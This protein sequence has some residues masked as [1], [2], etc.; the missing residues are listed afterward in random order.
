MRSKVSKSIIRT[1]QKLLKSLQPSVPSPD[2]SQSQHKKKRAADQSLSLR[3]VQ[4]ISNRIRLKVTSKSLW[5]DPPPNRP[6]W[7]FLLRVSRYF[8]LKLSQLI[9]LAQVN[10]KRSTNT[11][12]QI[13]K[14]WCLIQ[15]FKILEKFQEKVRTINKL[16]KWQRVRLWGQLKIKKMTL[17]KNW[18][19]TSKRKKIPK[20]HRYSLIRAQEQVASKLRW[21][22][23]QDQ[24][25]SLCK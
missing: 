12:L 14:S 2:Q 1:T 3:K 25:S 19:S 6:S 13:S 5:K 21:N 18:T 16:T 22:R 23:M 24:M 11:N 10:S 4:K 8:H 20:N 17:D 7:K 9:Q 15:Q